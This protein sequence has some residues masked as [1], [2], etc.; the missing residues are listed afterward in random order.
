ME[1]VILVKINVATM[2][3]DANLAS[4]VI[5]FILVLFNNRRI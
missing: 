3:P 5:I 4:E 1:F 2:I